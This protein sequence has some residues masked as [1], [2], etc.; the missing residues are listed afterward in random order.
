MAGKKKHIALRIIISSVLIIMVLAGSALIWLSYNYKRIIMLRFPAMIEK[1]SDS[2]YHASIEDIDIHFLSRTA[3][4]KGLKLWPDKEQAKAVR[5]RK[6][7]IPTT[8]STLNAPLVEIYGITWIDLLTSHSLD[9]DHVIVHDL[10]W[11]MEANPDPEDS[12]FEK[13]KKGEPELMRIRVARGDILQRTVTYKYEGAKTKFSCILCGGTG[14]L[15]HFVYNLDM[16]DSKDSNLFLYGNSGY[17]RPDSFLFIKT[18]NRY[19]VKKPNLDFETGTHSITLKSVKLENLVNVNEETRKAQEVYNLKFPNIVITGL[20]WNQLVNDGML[21]ANEIQATNPLIDIRYISE[22]TTPKGRMGDYPNQQLH[23][24]GLKTN[25]MK[26][27]MKDG[28]FRF[29]QPVEKSQQEGIIELEH[30]DCEITNITNMDSIVSRH[31]N[32]AIKIKAKY[33][34]KSNVAGTINLTL[35][36]VKGHFT[37]DGYLENLDA[38]DVT[39]QTQA[40]ALFEVTSLHMS[41]I[42]VKLEGDETYV[43]GGLTMLYQDL[44]ISFLKFQGDH[45]KNKKGPLS[46]IA[47]TILLYPQNPMPNKEVRQVTTTFARDTTKGFVSMVWENILRGAKKTAI[48]SNA[49]INVVDGPETTKGEKPKKGIFKRLFG[50]KNK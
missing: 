30:L 17:V 36:N 13:K 37:M 3:T 19:T 5:A 14:L 34:H 6:T 21:Q 26:L 16:N 1:G 2:I 46:F 9:C 49:M 11:L 20:N 4:I 8:L 18:G 23:E 10:V 28:L 50:K 41:K 48:R 42:D 35:G 32:C 47:N 43:A 22:N 31:D 27:T 25:I 29:T 7:H 15:N 40:F 45:R 44:K 33:N 24:V 12:L 38:A 39:K